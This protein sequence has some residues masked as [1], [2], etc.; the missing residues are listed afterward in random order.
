MTAGKTKVITKIHMI[1]D[2]DD[3]IFLSSILL[4]K[5]KL[6]LKIIHHVSYRDFQE[7]TLD[8]PEIEPE[9]VLVDLNLPGM[10]GTEVIEAMKN[11]PAYEAIIIG[12]CTGSD[13]PK[14]IFDSFATGADFFINK[15]LDLASIESICSKVPDLN[16]ISNEDGMLTL[17]K[18]R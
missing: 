7:F 1:E 15:P 3:E 18:N 10:K 12:I 11:N 17:H 13:D 8:N 5:Q 4:R 2:A 9:L 6:D 14:D 16:I